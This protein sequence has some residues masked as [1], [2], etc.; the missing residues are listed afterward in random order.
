MITALC[1]GVGGSK[2]VLGLY[3]VLPPN[4]LTVIVNTADDLTVWG[5]NVSPDLDTAMYTLSGLAQPDRGWGINH[6][7]FNAIDAMGPYGM[8][9]WF[10]VG[11]RDLATHIFRTAGLRDGKPLS[12]ITAEMTRALGIQAI[13]LPATDAPVATR[14]R[15][16]E[17]WL[18]FQEYFVHRRH[19]DPI[20]AVRYDGIGDARPSPGVIAAIESARAVILANSN[21]VLSILPIV[22]VPGVQAALSGKRPVVAV[23]P[24]IG[25][26]AV[27]GPAG[28]LMSVIGRPP[29]VV[30]LAEAYRGVIDGLV[31]DEQ[32]ANRA[33]EIEA[34]GI[35]VLCTETVMRSLADRERLAR[36]TVAFAK[37]LL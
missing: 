19:D 25:N 37:S 26:D 14:L 8:P 33:D 34:L 30:G 2:L 22:A 17:Q 10:R 28:R 29:T 21:P 11:D 20:N 6:D 16:G 7:T 5:L 24:L 1:G 9:T 12:T 23:S 27:T 4:T 15:S 36:E 32:D 35:R 13:I 31:I 18:D 3:R